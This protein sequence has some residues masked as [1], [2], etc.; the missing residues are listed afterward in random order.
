MGQF[1]W[2][3]YRPPKL[4]VQFPDDTGS[5]GPGRD[6][7]KVPVLKLRSTGDYFTSRRLSKSSSEMEDESQTETSE[8]E[9][10]LS[11]NEE[12]GGKL[13]LKIKK[14]K[15]MSD[16]E[17]VS[18]LLH[19]KKLPSLK[20]R[21]LAI[22]RSLTSK[23][24]SSG[25]VLCELFMRRP[26]SKLYPEYYIVIKQP[27]DLREILQKIREETYSSLEEMVHDVDLMAENACT[28]NEEESMVYK[29]SV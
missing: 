6:G 28:F 14:D 10:G 21:L 8:D 24:D 13:M 16:V 22:Y 2:S 12:G 3:F 25:R 29:V 4:S 19:M 17:P 11:S 9:E 18:K 7:K 15:L 26:S 23:M 20:R 27:I 1:H 5:T